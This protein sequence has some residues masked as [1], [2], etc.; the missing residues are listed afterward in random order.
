MW[1]TL[2]Y[3][4]RGLEYN[5]EHYMETINLT[6][7]IK[8]GTSLCAVIP[9]N[10][11]KALNWQRGDVLVFTNFTDDSLTLKRVSDKELRELKEIRDVMTR[12]LV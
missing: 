2:F 5:D 7:I 6:K 1:R 11:L 9:V 3:P 8:T 10:I 12:D 4:P